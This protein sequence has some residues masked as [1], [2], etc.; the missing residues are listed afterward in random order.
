MK[1][2]KQNQP[3]TIMETKDASQQIIQ[4]RANRYGQKDTNKVWDFFCSV[5]LAVVIILIMVVA[6]I[7]GTVILQ[8]KTL[9]EYT[10]RYGYGLATFFQNNTI[11]EC[12]LLLLVFIPAGITLCQPHL[13]YYQTVEKYLPADRLYTYPSQPCFNIDRRSCKISTWCKGR[14]KCLRGEIGGLFSYTND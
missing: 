8:E 5:K 9:D 7:L 10:A 2:G 3:R 4:K 14:R 6:C 11:V 1:N 12:L 13:L